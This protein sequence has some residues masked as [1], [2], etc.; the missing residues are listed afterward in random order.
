MNKHAHEAPAHP[1]GALWRLWWRFRGWFVNR[2]E[3]SRVFAVAM[4]AREEAGRAITEL[5]ERHEREIEKAKREAFE[6]VTEGEA[7]VAEA[8][9]L[10]KAAEIELSSAR[11]V[12]SEREREIDILRREKAAVEGER[13]L[14]IHEVGEL[15]EW[16]ERMRARVRADIAEEVA[17]EYR[18]TARAPG[19]NSAGPS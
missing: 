5:R 13:D 2:A 12:I 10:R 11:A 16:L 15:N 1:P 19:P 6:L 18:A 7:F 3:A 14:R 4:Q 9:R 8:E 17:R